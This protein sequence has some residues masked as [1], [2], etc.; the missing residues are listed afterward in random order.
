MRTLTCD[1]FVIG[2]GINGVG[3][4][5]D[6]A[7]RD[8][9]VILCEKDDLA[10]HT[11]S[12]SSKLIHGGLRYLEQV[13]L[14]LVH[15]ALREREILLHKAP[16]LV[17]PLPF[18][19]PHDKHLRP[20]WEIRLGLFLYD[21]LARRESLKKSKKLNLREVPEGKPL[22]EKFTI[23]FRYTDC[24]TDDARLVIANAK[25]ARDKNAVILTRTECQSAHRENGQWIAQLYDHLKNENITV[26]AKAI[27]NA[28]GPWVSQVLQQ[29]TR[30]AAAS[31]VKLI[32][33]S[34]FVVPKLYDGH[35][36]YILQNPD[37]RVV[38]AIPYQQDFTLIGT[39]DVI[40]TEDP[41]AVDISEEE[42]QYL[43]NTINHYFNEKISVAD[44]HW[45]YAGVRALYD[46]HASKPQKITREYHLD[47]SDESGAAPIISVFG[48]KIT[49]YRT[50]AEHVLR[51]LKPY[52]PAMGR[53]W[54]ET[55]MLPGGDLK[56]LSFD[57]FVASTQQQYAWLP[58]SLARRYAGSY[59]V[60]LHQLLAGAHALSD[61]GQHFGHDFYEIELR[62]LID[63]EWAIALEDILW[64]RSKL[65]LFLSKNEVIQLQQFFDSLRKAR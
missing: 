33:G 12:A 41:N 32:K 23:G 59:G 2:G 8:L 64:R 7:G 34:H 36:A 10:N 26:H 62:Y 30:T 25:A 18:I 20:A 5:A 43:C 6:A 16:H 57:Q 45:A 24:Q 48:G 15:E 35:F 37:R 11:S 22:K 51:D 29:V 47:L 63:H 65:G 14:K 31:Q 40:F 19:L 4:A 50:L 13:E 61:L 44:I 49:T 9:S 39:T 54:T 58:Q 17:H 56:G 28:A 3:V 55:A 52:F 53:P 38:F 60:E 21:Y 46:D 42:T 1:L 27:V